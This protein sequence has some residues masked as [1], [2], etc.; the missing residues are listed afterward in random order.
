[1][2]ACARANYAVKEARART[3]SAFYMTW[4]YNADT[5]PVGA[6]GESFLHCVVT[7][8]ALSRHSE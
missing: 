8:A 3:V 5:V 7:V 2:R 1:M 6:S 4:M